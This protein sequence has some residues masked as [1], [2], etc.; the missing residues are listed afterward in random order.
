MILLNKF[1][2][3]DHTRRILE[4]SSHRANMLRTKHANFIRH[5]TFDATN[6][7][8][9]YSILTRD[10]VAADSSTSVA[11]QDYLTY[12]RAADWT[13][14][15]FYCRNISIHLNINLKPDDNRIFLRRYP[16]IDR[17]DDR[18]IDFGQETLSNALKAMGVSEWPRDAAWE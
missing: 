16:W 11:P 1:I 15:N 10:A 7:V 6:R 13:T 9:L 18:E 17:I 4:R 12:N 8:K 2:L 5:Y 14:I 3:S